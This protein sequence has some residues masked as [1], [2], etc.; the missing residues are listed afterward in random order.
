MITVLAGTTT[1]PIFT[2]PCF[3]SCYR[4]LKSFPLRVRPFALKGLLLPTFL[5]YVEIQ[6]AVRRRT[7]TNYPPPL[8][9]LQEA[10]YVRHQLQPKCVE[11][12]D[13]HHPRPLGLVEKGKRLDHYY[14]DVSNG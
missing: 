8:H 6:L 4:P 10:D 12:R 2:L 9:F 7:I 11:L 3:W 1:L 13:G 5:H 14:D